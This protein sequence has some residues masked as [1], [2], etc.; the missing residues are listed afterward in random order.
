V[1]SF[2]HPPEGCLFHPRCPGAQPECRSREPVLQALDGQ[3][4]VACHFPTVNKQKH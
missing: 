4:S 2:R 3:R 1:P